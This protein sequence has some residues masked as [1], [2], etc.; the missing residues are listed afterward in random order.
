[1]N[2][3]KISSVVDGTKVEGIG[4]VKN[5]SYKWKLAIESVVCSIAQVPEKFF[6]ITGRAYRIDTNRK[7]SV[8]SLPT[9]ENY[10]DAIIYKINSISP[11]APPI[12][13]IIYDY[14]MESKGRLGSLELTVNNSEYNSL[15]LAKLLKAAG[16]TVMSDGIIKSSGGVI[17]YYYPLDKLTKIIVGD[18]DGSTYDYDYTFPV[19]EILDEN[20]IAYISNVEIDYNTPTSSDLITYNENH[21]MTDLISDLGLD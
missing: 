11:G 13:K 4:Y 17:Q 2:L 8:H 14:A 21:A 16:Y 3:L 10:K 7:V 5:H 18:K 9:Y 1:M 6:D 15:T 12:A 19:Y 20:I